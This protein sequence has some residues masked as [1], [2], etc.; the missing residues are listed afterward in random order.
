MRQKLSIEEVDNGY[1]VRV[2]KTGESI[3]KDPYVKPVRVYET[4]D[5]L[6]NYLECLKPSSLEK[7][8]KQGL[9][10]EGQ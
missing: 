5:A 7:H 1:I 8:R 3:F 4:F 6:M 2:I 9:R 10:P